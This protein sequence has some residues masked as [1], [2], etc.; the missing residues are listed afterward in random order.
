MNNGR[1]V[2]V[3]D[4]APETPAR[5]GSLS[6]MGGRDRSAVPPPASPPPARRGSTASLGARPMSSCSSPSPTS[7]IALQSPPNRYVTVK[8]LVPDSS[9]PERAQSERAVPVPVPRPR[10]RPGSVSGESPMA[11]SSSDGVDVAKL[12]LS[13]QKKFFLEQQREA[14]QRSASARPS[15][16]HLDVSRDSQQPTSGLAAARAARARAP[17]PASQPSFQS[18]APVM[19]SNSLPAEAGGP[20]S[21]LRSNSGEYVSPLP[22]A[23]WWARPCVLFLIVCVLYFSMCIC[24]SFLVHW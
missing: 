7:P 23:Q 4:R 20:M 22:R 17:L 8:T 19:R 14:F 1:S 16:N 2:P 10:P 13:E 6:S 11:R 3:Y 5:R 9:S 24:E 12:P 15:D 21:P 18:Q